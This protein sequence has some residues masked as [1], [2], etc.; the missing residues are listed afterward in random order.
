MH[1][2][3]EVVW[4]KKKV[5]EYWDIFGNIT[6]V[7]PW[8]SVKASGWLLKEINKIIDPTAVFNFSQADC[9]WIHDNNKVSNF[10]AY[11]GIYDH[12][13][14]LIIVNEYAYNIVF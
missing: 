11:A 9:K 5:S 10:N 1:N 14:I 7:S 3:H 12:K 2:A 6:P 13:F 4:D 8:F